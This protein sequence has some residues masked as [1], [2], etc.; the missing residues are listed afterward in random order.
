VSPDSAAPPRPARADEDRVRV[1][2]LVG[3]LASAAIVVAFFLPWLSVEPDQAAGYLRR[4]EERFEDPVHP[5]PEGVS[6]PD[7]LR[8]AG[9]AAE[10]GHVSGLDVFYWARMAGKTAEAYGRAEH[11]G[12]DEPPA[13]LSRAIRIVAIV[14]GA[15]PVVA[16]LIALTFVVQ[17]FRRAHSPTL[18]L[19]VLGGAVAIAV[20]AAHSIV[21]SGLEV[22]SESAVGLHLL[23]VAGPVL[24]LAGVFGV[25]LKNWWRVFTGAVIVGGGLALLAWAWLERGS[26]S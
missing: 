21:E 13:T 18:V 14:L 5:V 26:A 10:Q 25:R 9:I 6:K 24:L 22:R 23:G 15:L 19:A 1:T 4:M 12:R 3:T 8:L 7:W 2:S 17:R 16:L 20:P 11:A